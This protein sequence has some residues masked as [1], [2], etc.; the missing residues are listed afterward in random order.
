MVF[1]YH[2]DE[3]LDKLITEKLGIKKYMRYMDDMV[4][5]DNAK[6]VLH[7]VIEEIQKFIG[8]RFRLKLKRTFQVCKWKSNRQGN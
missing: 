6:K 5:F 2:K 4:F 7:K 3:P 8:R 1:V